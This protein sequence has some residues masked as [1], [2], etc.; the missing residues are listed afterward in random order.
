[1][2]KKKKS[3]NI[4]ITGLISQVVILLLG[5][6]IPKLLIVSYGS[7]VNG[8]LSSIKQIFVYV[9]LLEA[10]IGTA[11]LQA[12][13]EPIAKNDKEKASE[14]MVATDRYFKRTG[15]FYGI[16]VVLLAVLYPIVIKVELEYWM[17][18]VIILLQGSAGVIKY[19]FQGKLTILLRVDGRSY[20]TTNIATIVNVATHLIQIILILSGFDIIAVQIAYFIINLIQMIYLTWY[21]RKNYSW[22]NWKATPNYKALSQS[23]FVIVHQISGLIFNNTDVLILTYFC[24]L[25]VVSVYSLYSLIF[26]CVS[27]VID[28]LCSSVEFILGQAFNSDKEYFMK[29]QET[30]ETYYLGISF[31]F[32]TI[33]LIMFPSFIK[34]YSSGITDINYVDP[35]LPYLFVALNVL[36]YARRTSSQIINFAGHFKQT[37]WRSILESAINLTVSLV[38]VR[39]LGVYGVLIGT[40]FALFYRTNDVI[41]Y[42]NWNILGRKPWKTYRRWATNLVVMCVLAV[43]IK[44][45]LGPISNYIQWFANAVWVGIVCM[46]GFICVDSICDPKSYKLVKKMAVDFLKKKRG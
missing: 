33:T 13:Y 41:I 25:K 26:S 16:A 7:E 18:A 32:F 35:I 8:L 40:I 39:Y 46:A 5:I 30:Y 38:M 1:M 19:F 45:I 31:G 34:L 2:D 12:M 29:L 28:T 15:L 44:S 9:A 27:N 24:G 36:M 14:I 10:G 23:K 42:A 6:V 20:V 43:G 21:V 3:L 17:V 37:Q 22:L 11:A 4:F